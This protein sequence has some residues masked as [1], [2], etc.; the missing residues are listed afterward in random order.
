M[1]F[2]KLIV[3]L[4]LLTSIAHAQ[5]TTPANKKHQ[6]T[7]A[8]AK[9]SSPYLLMHAHNP[10]NWMAWNEQTLAKAKQDDRK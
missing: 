8:L 5:E 4:L 7:N 3:F 1:S 6:H 2:F 10:V 9:E